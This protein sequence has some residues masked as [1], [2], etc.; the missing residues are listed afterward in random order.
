MNAGGIEI[1]TVGACTAGHFCEV[2]GDDHCADLPSCAIKAT[3]SLMFAHG[4]ETPLLVCDH[5]AEK[6]L[7]DFRGEADII[8]EVGAERLRE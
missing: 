5:C 8:F 4:T 7:D 6:I 2:C 3:A 1:I